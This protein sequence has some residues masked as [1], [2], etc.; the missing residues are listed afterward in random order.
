MESRDED[1][2][3]DS[4]AAVAPS[5]VLVAAAPTLMM[6]GDPYVFPAEGRHAILVAV[7]QYAFQVEEL[8]V[9]PEVDRNEW[10]EVE[11]PGSEV[12]QSVCSVVE[13]PCVEGEHSAG[14]SAPA[15]AFQ[16]VRVVVTSA[17]TEAAEHRGVSSAVS[18]PSGGDPGS[19]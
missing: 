16:L 8:N 10:P 15:V 7:A 19:D 1:R 2:F 12:E 4:G 11:D 6:V 3:S 18:L 5:E 9:C 13:G 17:M 14:P